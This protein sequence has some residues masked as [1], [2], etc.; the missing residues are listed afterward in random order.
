MRVPDAMTQ[1]ALFE[2]MARARARRDDALLQMASGRRVVSPSDDPRAAR[3]LLALADESAAVTSQLR[4]AGV[5]RPWLELAEDVVSTIGERLTRASVLA[6]QG[7]STALTSAQRA[8]LADEVAGIRAELIAMSERQLD[9][10]F[11]F[12]GT[13]TDTAPFDAAGAYQGNAD[14]VEI[15]LDGQAVA[16]NLPGNAVFGEVGVG[17]PLDTLARLEAAL[18]ADDI[19]GIQAAA[20]ALDADLAANSTT[21]AQVGTRLIEIDQATT[22]LEDRKLRLA[23]RADELGAADLAEAITAAEQ[24][25]AHYQATL[26]ATSRLFGPTLFDY[27]G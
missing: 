25:D 2:L 14:A 15:R 16:L 11:V 21:L 4:T 3:E 22:R 19:A 23:A 10:R 18:R 26:A 5:A 17:G 1:Q 7:A 9:G 13:R 8:S 24:G 27:L 20:G 12:S 6:V